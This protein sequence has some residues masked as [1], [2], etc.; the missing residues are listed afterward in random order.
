MIAQQITS[1]AGHKTARRFYRPELDALRFFAFLGVLVCHG[2][3]PR[4]FPDFVSRFGGFGLSMFFLLSAYLITELLLREREQ[5]GRVDWG[6]FFI[7]RALRIWP[8][9]FAALAVGIIMARIL[10]HRFPIAGSGIAAMSLFVANWIPVTRLGGLLFPLWTISIE[11]QFY[12]IWPPIIKLGGKTAALAASIIFAI[13]AAIW[14]WIFSGKGF[15]LWFDTPVQF[16]FFAAGAIIALVLHGNRPA[17]LKL[18]NGV[19]R[20][21]LLIVGLFALAI[22]TRFGR[23]M[24][25]IQLHDCHALPGYGT[26]AVGCALVFI[27]TFGISNVPRALTYFGKISYGLYVFHPGGL[28][29][30]NSLASLLKL[31]RSSLLRM[32]IIDGLSLLLCIV[33]AHISYRYFERPFL[34]LKERF[35]V[36]HSRPA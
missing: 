32:F 34:R 1:G 23:I 2:P 14:M 7:R 35:E 27:A 33:A 5:S 9:Y 36:I 21:G 31:Q 12:L 10:P 15:Y 6:L 22:A 28:I 11:E 13:S 8:L 26:A 18:L 3:R 17:L 4:G 16:S 25:E 19:T 29:L 30:S 20:S 24:P